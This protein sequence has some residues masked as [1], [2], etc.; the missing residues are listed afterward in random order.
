MSGFGPLELRKTVTALIRIEQKQNELRNLILKDGRKLPDEKLFVKFVQSEDSL[1]F[2]VGLEC[3]EMIVHL[4]EKKN[5]NKN[6][7]E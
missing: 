7:K 2:Y 5:E 1:N 6:N 3:F 4:K